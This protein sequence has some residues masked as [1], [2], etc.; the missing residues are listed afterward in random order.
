MA[1]GWGL[2]NYK[3]AELQQLA[4]AGRLQQLD[5]V[6]CISAFG[7]IHAAEY[8]S[9][10]MVSKNLPDQSSLEVGSV[11]G[12]YY[13]DSGEARFINL[14]TVVE[15]TPD[16]YDS[17]RFSHNLWPSLWQPP[18]HNSIGWDTPN[19]NMLPIADFS[20]IVHCLAEQVDSL[21]TV[22]TLPALQ[23]LVVIV[24][25]VK[26]AYLLVI[27]FKLRAQPLITIGDAIASYLTAPDNNLR[28]CKAIDAKVSVEQREP[29]A[30]PP[31]IWYTSPKRH[32]WFRGVSVT[33][34]IVTGLL[35][36]IIVDS[37]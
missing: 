33:R 12:S 36:D 30:P 8:A 16:D 29:V 35:Y 27:F 5:P 22:D 37:H 7:G 3:L 4:V 23:G 31:P 13:P 17:Q 25:L 34:W 1:E 14:T 6:D 26:L 10:L 15:L 19:E 24:N 28:H 11:L 21:C 2:N 9:V 20:S 32:Q 18:P